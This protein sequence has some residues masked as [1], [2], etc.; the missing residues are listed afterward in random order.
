MNSSKSVPVFFRMLGVMRL[1]SS[2]WL[3]LGLVN[4]MLNFQIFF[5]TKIFFR[6]NPQGC[7]VTLLYQFL[8]LKEL[9]AIKNQTCHTQECPPLYN[10][11]RIWLT[12][13]KLKHHLWMV[14]YLRDFFNPCLLH[15]LKIANWLN[16][17][18]PCAHCIDFVCK[19]F[20]P[21]IEVKVWTKMGLGRVVR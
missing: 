11:V 7:E 15:P 8:F 16:D 19:V 10:S 1:Q 17:I 18:R 5:G 4:K 6:S 14:P 9:L 20:Y 13:S 12:S 21:A 2:T 3:D